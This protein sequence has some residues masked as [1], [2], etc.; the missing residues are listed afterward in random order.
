MFGLKSLKPSSFLIKSF[1]FFPTEL[2]KSPLFPCNMCEANSIFK[3]DLV[4]G[5][6]SGDGLILLTDTENPVS[7]LLLRLQFTLK[8]VASF[9]W[10]LR[11][12]RG[13][14]SRI[15]PGWRTSL[16]IKYAHGARRL[17]IYANALCEL[18]TKTINFLCRLMR[19]SHRELLF[20]SLCCRG[21]CLR[22]FTSETQQ[23]QRQGFQYYATVPCL[24]NIPYTFLIFSSTNKRP[25]HLN[26]LESKWS[27]VWW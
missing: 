11:A 7:A 22:S 25:F 1:R 17:S 12:N 4:R 9:S 21:C 27:V 15:M 20:T 6:V 2:G 19:V 8:G 24:L 3:A 18:A 10:P 23:I 16:C 26:E 13:S 14:A 5:D